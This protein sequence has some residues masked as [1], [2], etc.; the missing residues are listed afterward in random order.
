[1]PNEMLA[2]LKINGINALGINAAIL[3]KIPILL[4][5]KPK[6]ET[7]SLIF[8]LFPSS[9][10]L[11]RLKAT[12]VPIPISARL[13]KPKMFTSVPESPRKSAPKLFRKIFLEKKESPNDKK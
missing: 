13:R 12:A 3:I 4:Y 1:M 5:K 8:C 2:F 7:I 11:Y 9:N 10:G 6:T